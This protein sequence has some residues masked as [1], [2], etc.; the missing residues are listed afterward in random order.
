MYKI[1][2]IEIK[3]KEKKEYNYQ[4]K[5]NAEMKNQLNIIKGKIVW[6][7]KGKNKFKRWKYK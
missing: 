7:S 4:N 2:N 5:E 3:E 1:H 6:K